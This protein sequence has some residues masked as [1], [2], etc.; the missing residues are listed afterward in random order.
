M[1]GCAIFHFA[2]PFH[3][4]V[5]RLAIANNPLQ[6]DTPNNRYGREVPTVSGE[7]GSKINV[8][9]STPPPKGGRV[10]TDYAYQQPLAEQRA[11]DPGT[12]MLL[13]LGL[14]FCLWAWF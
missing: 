3:S 8:S 14:V 2:T 7:I 10:Q 5:P 9:A 4:P 6:H 13:D 12:G 1:H 11:S